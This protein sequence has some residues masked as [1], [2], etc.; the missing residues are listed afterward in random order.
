MDFKM[1]CPNCHAEIN[2]GKLLGSVSTDA[3]A[4]AARVNG[5]NGGRPPKIHIIKEGRAWRWTVGNK[6]GYCATKKDAINDAK[7]ISK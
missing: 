2:I 5:A 7:I 6:I 3:K 1:K 4:A